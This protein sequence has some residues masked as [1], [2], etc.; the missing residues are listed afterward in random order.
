MKCTGR[1]GPSSLTGELLGCV[2]RLVWRCPTASLGWGAGACSPSTG[3]GEGSGDMD[4]SFQISE[5]NAA[6]KSPRA[7]GGPG[8]RCRPARPTEAAR[9]CLSHE[10]PLLGEVGRPACGRL[11]RD[12]NGALSRRVGCRAPNNG[13]GPAPLL[14]PTA[15]GRCPGA[16]C[17]CPGGDLWG[18]P[19]TPWKSP[20]EGRRRTMGTSCQAPG[21]RLGSGLPGLSTAW[22]VLL[23]CWARGLPGGP[24][25]WRRVRLGVGGGPRSWPCWPRSAATDPAQPPSLGL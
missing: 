25:A 16:P 12:N 19:V 9:L 6:W 4:F 18:C 15:R 3:A 14:L 8:A 23:L 21:P 17:E 10:G 2:P 13:P 20:G 1:G 7:A 5:L 24:P 22:Q 11:L